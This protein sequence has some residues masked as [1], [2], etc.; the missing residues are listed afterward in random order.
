[1]RYL[2]ALILLV[3]SISVTL[4]QTGT[5]R[6]NVFDKNTGEPILYANIFLEN[7]ELATNTYSDGFFTLGNVP[8]GNYTILV[9]YIGYD[10]LRVPVTVTA[11][12]IQ[13][14]SL[15]LD[16]SSIELSTVSVSGKKEV[17]RTEVQIST[18]KVTAR[19]IKAIPSTGGEADIAQYLQIIPGVISTGDQGGQ[20]YIRGGSP[21]QNLVLL[22]GMP[23]Y[24]PFHSI[25]FFSVFETEAIRRVDVLTGGFNAEYGGRI[26]AIVDIKTR[27]GNK[28]RFGGLVSVSP[29]IAKTLLEGPI[30]PLKEGRGTSISY[31][32]TGKHSFI[33]QTSKALYPYAAP[34]SLGLPFNF[35]DYYGKITIAGS[36]G[37]KLNLFGFNFTDNVRYPGIADFNW[38]AYGGGANFTLIPSSSSLVIDGTVGFS[39]YQIGLQEADEEPRTSAINGF[40]V[41]LNFTY[42]GNN[43][44]L[45]YGLAFNGFTTNFKFRNFLGIT[46]SQEENTTEL[47]GYIKYRQKLGDLIIEP[48]IRAQ[49]YASLSNFSLEPRIGLKYN[50][51]DGLRLKV[52]G[53]FYS[54]NLI[55]TVNE[56]D[57]VNLF[58]GFLSGPE[59][60]IFQPGTRTPTDHRLQKAVH[61]IGGV[62]I[63]L[64]KNLELNVE[65]YYKGFTQLINVNR[66]KLSAQDPNYAVETGEAYGI[67]FLLKYQ[68]ADWLFWGGYSLGYVNRDDGEQIYPTIFDRRH[69]TNLL[70]TYAFGHNNSWEASARWNFG[71]GFPFT[72][73]QGFFGEQIFRNGLDS[74][75]RTDNPDLGIIYDE[76]RN[77]GR[78]PTYHRLDFSLTKTWEFTKYMNLKANFSVTNAYDRNNI[79]YFDRIRYERVDQLPILPS[80]GLTFTF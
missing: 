27:E 74:D 51:S 6:G 55:S 22:D 9:T 70:V 54:Q 10:S 75:Y 76:V 17:A 52:A 19:E 11:N 66:N 1:M 72:Q 39:D 53:G 34:D 58:V 43:S 61:A 73:T 13:Y 5:I 45:K 49:Y 20:I 42:F 30:I 28:K 18:L 48:S 33:D 16:E 68:S 40:N 3:A 4:G 24:N 56:R 59:Q 36:S 12:Q 63:D 29:F 47:A 21:V 23:I 60:I 62:E 57:V 44:E 26:S 64:M 69:N 67:D 78:L 80:V 25:G 65:P 2:I 31:L 50:V 32:I 15:Y 8:V 79:F 14:K 7:T 41:N 37:S 71:T 46:F 35:T 77:G 38:K